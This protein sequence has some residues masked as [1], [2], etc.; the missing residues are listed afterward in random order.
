[1]VAMA[2][3]TVSAITGMGVMLAMGVIITDTVTD[4]DMDMGTDTVGTGL[5]VITTT[6]L[7]FT[8]RHR[9]SMRRLRPALT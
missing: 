7:H 8:H 4:M 3:D 1:M 9:S 2:E 6:L 5:T